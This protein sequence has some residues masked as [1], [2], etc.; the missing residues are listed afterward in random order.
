MRGQFTAGVLDYLMDEGLLPK[1]V[2]GVSAGALNGLNYVA[3]MRGRTCHLNT[4]YCKDWRYLSLRSLITTGDIFGVDYCYETV[5]KKVDLFDYDAF[6]RS[7]LNLTTVATDLQTGQARYYQLQDALTQIDY[8]RASASMPLVSR[9]VKIENAELLDGGVAKSVPLEFALDADPNAKVIVVLTQADGYIKKPQGLKPLM[10]AKYSRYP[11]FL[12]TLFNRHIEY[13]ATY[14]LVK[15]LAATG[16]ILLIRP[17]TPVTVKNMEHDRNK[18]LDLWQ[19]GY[20]E[21]RKSLQDGVQ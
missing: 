21:A 17:P 10:R 8:L 13:N 3:G 11:D 15:K 9:T 5:P 14:H 18:L 2:I 20:T 4:T 12:H 16:Q 7:P 1:N 6:G 19:T